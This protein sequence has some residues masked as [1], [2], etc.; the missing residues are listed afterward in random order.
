MTRW[1]RAMSAVKTPAAR[2][3]AVA[4]ARAMTSSSSSKSRTHTTGPKISSRAMV[5]SSVTPEKTVGCTKKPP[6][7]CGWTRSPPV[8][9]VR[10]FGAALG[11]V[12]HDLRALG[13]GDQRTHLHGLV[14][15]VAERDPLG[16]G[17]EAVEEGVADG[18][19]DEDAGAVRADLAGGVEVAEHRAAD[20]AVEIGVL[21]DDERRFAAELERHVLHPGR[22]GGVDPGAGRDRAGDGDLGD[23]G[24]GG[25]RGP[26]R[27]APWTT[28]KAPAGRPA[29]ARI[30]PSLSAPSGVSSEGLKIIALPQA[31]AGAAFQ[32]AI[33]VG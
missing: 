18:A 26:D 22:G 1:A 25:E 33:W 14:H 19:M 24:M 12:V 27:A 11:D 8:R 28:L 20:G 15:G 4:L 9:S 17:D 21:E 31:S 32:Q 10:A 5:I 3:K 2:P 7:P 23:R 6:K 30:S 13:G 29:S 16:A